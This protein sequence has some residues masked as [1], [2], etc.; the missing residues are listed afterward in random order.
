M[1]EE[2]R[3]LDGDGN[4]MRNTSVALCIEVIYVP[5]STSSPFVVEK[6]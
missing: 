6:R 4:D 1:S 3:R 2:G 5:S